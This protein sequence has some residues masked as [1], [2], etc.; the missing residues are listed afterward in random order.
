MLSPTPFI[1]ILTLLLIVSLLTRCSEDQLI[2]MDSLERDLLL[3]WIA[4]EREDTTQIAEYSAIAQQNWL[5]LQRH[6]GSA[7]VRPAFLQSAMRVNMWMLKLRHA[8]DYKQP[9]QASVAIHLM[10][11]ELR[12]LHP[13]LGT[14][15]PTDHLYDF[16]YQWQDVVAASNDPMVE[17]LEWKEFEE[18]F[19]LA[20]QSWTA[21]VAKRPYFSNTLFP[22]YGQNASNSEVAS[23]A[24]TRSLE[25]FA[26]LLEEADH[27]LVADLSRKIDKL[28]FDYLAVVTAYPT[29]SHAA[30]AAVQ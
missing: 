5:L 30:E 27:T 8:V 20:T 18:C 7:R 24:M 1:G 9:E 29:P 23:L 14:T 3:T 15:H 22:G 21:Y 28:F 26:T 6:Y 25:H 2:E 13:Q 19:E 16:Y 17:L 10:Q 4:L 12:I 11:N